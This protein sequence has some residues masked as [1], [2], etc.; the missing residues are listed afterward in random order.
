MATSKLWNS[1]ESTQS[2]ECNRKTRRFRSIAGS[3]ADRLCPEG[4]NTKF[5]GCTAQPP[6]HWLA[7]KVLHEVTKNANKEEKALQTKGTVA[8]QTVMD[9]RASVSAKETEITHFNI[10]NR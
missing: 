10:E 3:P 5:D 4:L 1:V 6:I 8:R 2:T 7:G 9:K